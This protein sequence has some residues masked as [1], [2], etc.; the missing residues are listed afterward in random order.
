[1]Y[2][3]LYCTLYCNALSNA[4]QSAMHYCIIPYIVLRCTVHRA[5]LW[6]VLE[7]NLQD[8]IYKTG[9]QRKYGMHGSVHCV[10]LHCPMQYKL[11]CT[12]VFGPWNHI[13]NA[14]LL[15]MAR[16]RYAQI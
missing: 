2:N 7:E 4:T 6:I 12:I 9:I 11:Q 13:T 14:H 1:M 16:Q 8:I 15:L 3:A 5:V 10:T